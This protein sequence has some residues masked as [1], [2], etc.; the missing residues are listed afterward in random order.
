MKKHCLAIGLL[1]AGLVG[2][3]VPAAAAGGHPFDGTWTETI[4]GENQLCPVRLNVTF[5]I[6]NS[7]LNTEHSQGTISPN[8]AA[9]GTA[10][11][12]GLTATWSGRFSAHSAS[13]RFRR[14]DGCIGRWEAVR[15]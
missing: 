5:V 7:R 13:G 15:Q 11:G 1:A 4:I 2:T 10:Q 3:S 14:S 8:G 9:R 12:G 6:A